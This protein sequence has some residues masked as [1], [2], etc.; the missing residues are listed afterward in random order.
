[1]TSSGGIFP[2][3][4]LSGALGGRRFG[5]LSACLESLRVV[6]FRDRKCDNRFRWGYME[7]GIFLG[8]VFG[9]FC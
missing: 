2:V 1:M 4:G 8:F 3:R 9:P 5:R 7:E 6:P